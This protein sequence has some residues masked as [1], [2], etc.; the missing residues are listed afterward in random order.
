M[1]KA[2]RCAKYIGSGSKKHCARHK[3]VPVSTAKGI[4]QGKHFFHGDRISKG[5][6]GVKR[7]KRA[8]KLDSK[9]IGRKYETWERLK[10][11]RWK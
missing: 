6:W 7:W 3:L 11:M 9:R 1:V 5:N 10:R 4:R 2:R 8:R